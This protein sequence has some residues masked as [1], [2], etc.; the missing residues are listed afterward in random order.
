M[1][2]RDAFAMAEDLVEHH[3]PPGWSVQYDAARR[4]AGVCRFRDRVIGLSAPLTALHD[5]SEVRDTVLHEIAHALAGPRHGHDEVWREVAQRIGSTGER[6]VPADA[7]RVEAPW[8]G[9]CAQGHTAER[10]RRP[11]RV[12]SCARCGRGFSVDRIFT[13]THEGRPAVM[14]PN[15]E[16]ELD[17]LRHGTRVVRL[18][19][20]TR[21]RITPAAGSE[22][23]GR[24]GTVLKRGRTRYHLRCG[25][26]TL[27]VPFAW[28]E[29]V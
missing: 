8:I 27:T 7:P 19:P 28:V 9:V 11:E 21:V 23:G 5:E 18:A 26:Q 3:C 15:Y 14:H 22:H 16:A 17:Q 10:F 13:W 29:R 2:L 1:D 6:C 12:M 25:R 4:R 24:T 20:G